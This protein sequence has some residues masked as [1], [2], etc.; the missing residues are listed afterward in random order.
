M[1]LV[2]LPRR[3]LLNPNIEPKA[4]AKSAWRVFSEST[5]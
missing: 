1:A 4:F 2:F 3:G 5:C